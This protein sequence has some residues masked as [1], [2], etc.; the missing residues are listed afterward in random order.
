MDIPFEWDET[1]KKFYEVAKFCRAVLI[2]GN[3]QHYPLDADIMNAA[4]FCSS[5]L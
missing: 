2:T 1:D 4:D 5:Y 3:L